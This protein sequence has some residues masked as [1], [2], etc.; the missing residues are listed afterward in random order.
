MCLEG[1]WRVIGRGCAL[2]AV[3]L[4]LLPLAA[5]AAAKT[6]AK[7]RVIERGPHHAEVQSI[8]TVVDAAGVERQVTRTYVTVGSGLHQFENGKW[9]PARALFEVRGREIVARKTAHKVSLASSPAAARPVVVDLPGGGGKQVSRVLGL[10]YYD[11]GSGRSVLLAEVRDVNQ[12]Q[13][14]ETEVIYPDAFDGGFRVDL[15]YRI[16]LAGL[17][18]DVIVRERPPAPEEYG[19]EAATTRLEVLT[20]FLSTPKPK[21]E[22]RRLRARGGDRRLADPEQTDDDVDFGAMVLGPG[23]AFA[24]AAERE[25]EVEGGG[26]A[27]TGVGIGVSKRWETIEGRQVLFEAVEWAEAAPLLEGL[28]AGAQARRE[29]VGGGERRVAQ[30]GRFELPGGTRAVPQQQEATPTAAAGAAAVVAG[31]GEAGLEPGAALLAVAPL[32][33]RESAGLVID[34]QTV[35]PATNFTFR[36]DTTYYV[37]NGLYLRGTTTIE[38]GTVVKYERFVAPNYVSLNLMGPVVCKTSAYRPGVFTAKDDDSVGERIQGSTGVVSGRYAWCSIYL[39]NNGSSSVL[40]HLQVRHTVRGLYAYYM[41]QVTTFRHV[42]V[43]NA[44]YGIMGYVANVKVGNALIVDVWYPFYQYSAPMAVEHATVQR[45][46]YLVYNQGNS[47]ISLVNSLLAQ[48]TNQTQYGSFA[49]SFTVTNASSAAFQNVG[50]GG[51]YLPAGSAHRDAGTSGIDAGLWSELQ[52]LT[53]EAPQVW[54]QAVTEDTTLGPRVS[55]DVGAPDLGYHYAPLDYCIGE[56]ALSN[57]TLRLVGGVALGFTGANGG[58]SLGQGAR[59]LSQGSPLQMNRWVRYLQVQEHAGGANDPWHGGNG[60]ATW[61]YLKLATSASSGWPEMRLRFTEVAHLAHAA[62]RRGLLESQGYPFGV[63]EVRDSRLMNVYQHVWRD[64]SGLGSGVNPVPVVG[65]TNNVIERGYVQWTQG[66]GNVPRALGVSLRNNLFWGGYVGFT[67]YT[68]QWPWAVH[69]NLFDGASL[70]EGGAGT[71]PMPVTHNAYTAGVTLLAGSKDHLKGMTSGY[72]SGPLGEYYYPESGAWPTLVNLRDKGSRAAGAAG[73]YYYTTRPGQS[74]ESSSVV[75]IGFH[76]LAVDASGRVLDS[77]GDGLEDYLEDDNGNGTIDAWESSPLA[78]DSD[79]DG[80]SDAQEARFGLNARLADSDGDGVSDGQ[81]DLD[82]DGMSVLEEL[83]LGTDPGNRDTDGDGVEDGD[84]DADGDLLTNRSELRKYG[85]NPALRRS[86]ASPHDDGVVKCLAFENDS[87]TELRLGIE[88]GTEEAVVTLTGTVA[89]R[90]YVLLSRTS[91]SGGSGS[92][93]IEQYVEGAAGGNVTQARVAYGGRE[94]LYVMA[95]LG[96]DS[97]GDGLVDAYEVYVLKTCP[98]A[99][100]SGGTATDDGYRDP[101][102]DQWTNMQ[103]MENRTDPLLFNSPPAPTGLQALISADNT[104][105]ELKWDPAPGPVVGYMVQSGFDDPVPV[106][107]SATSLSVD[108]PPNGFAYQLNHVHAL[109][110]RGP[111]LVTPGVVPQSEIGPPRVVNGANGRLFLVVPNRPRNAAFVRL[112]RL[113]EEPTTGLPIEHVYPQFDWNPLWLDGEY[114]T[115]G[116][117]HRPLTVNGSMDIPASSLVNGRFEIPL[118]FAPYFGRYCFQVQVVYEDGMLGPLQFCRGMVTT[119]VRRV[120]FIDGREMLE[121]NARFLLRAAT[122]SE[123][124]GYKIAIDGDD[125]DATYHAAAAHADYVVSDY[126][127]VDENYYPPKLW[128][129]FKPAQEN[130]FY[131]NWCYSADNVKEGWIATGVGYHIDGGQYYGR[132]FIFDPLHVFDE[133]GYVGLG[134]APPVAATLTAAAAKWIYHERLRSYPDTRVGLTENGTLGEGLKNIYGLPYVSLLRLAPEAENQTQAVAPGGRM[135]SPPGSTFQ[136]VKEPVLLTNGFYFTA[137]PRQIVGG[138]EWT[139]RTATPGFIGVVGQPMWIAGWERLSISNSPPGKAVFLGQ[140]FDKAYLADAEGEPTT[141]ETGILSEYGEFFPTEPGRVILVTKPGSSGARGECAIQVIGIALDAD[142]DG[143]M[144]LQYGGADQTSPERPLRFWV[145]DDYDAVDEGVDQDLE[146]KARSN[147]DAK[148]IAQIE[149]ERDLEDFAR[150]WLP[151]VE[152]VQVPGMRVLLSWNVRSGSPRINLFR[153]ENGGMGYLRSSDTARTIVAGSAASYIGELGAQLPMDLTEHMPTTGTPYFLFEGSS[154]GSGDLVLTLLSGWTFVGQ[155]RASLD[156]N[157]VRDLYEQVHLLGVPPT[158]SDRS[159]PAFAFDHVPRLQ[160]DERRELVVFVHGWRMTQWDFYSF[161]ESMFKRL[162]W[163]GFAGRV[164]SVRWPT[165][166]SDETWFDYRTFNASEYRAHH[167]GRALSDYLTHRKRKFPN[168]SIHV[169]AHSM[170]NTV[171][172]QALKRQHERGRN[173]VTTWVLMQA[174]VPAHCFDPGLSDYPKLASTQTTRPTP[175][176]YR[177]VLNGISTRARLVSFV[178]EEDYALATGTLEP[179]PNVELPIANWESHQLR[180]KPDTSHYYRSHGE[181]GYKFYF[182]PPPSG[183]LPQPPPE[184]IKY[185]VSDPMEM[186]AFVARPR[187]KAVGAVLGVGG[188]LDQTGETD[189]GGTAYG[190]GRSDRDHS[191]QFNWSIQRLDAFY[192]QLVDVME[193]GAGR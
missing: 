43:V 143:A 8:E 106:P 86:A 104:K 146:T 173:D 87:G 44:H 54:T 7:T 133:P 14:V 119:H 35:V 123:P 132:K 61:S 85:T 28:P 164:A 9:E 130:R 81:E 82:Y 64:A 112:V 155:A 145:N 189:L 124:F 63:Y 117:A 166:S 36:S 160:T 153:V 10:G 34:Y 182:Q 171:M 41:P 111:S 100:D 52:Q 184:I 125:P 73:L 96:E 95:G 152:G 163:Q 187:S 30:A 141:Q 98:D 167:S 79:A 77:D 88:R 103:E 188:F 26:G 51:Q 169:C 32:D 183:P 157:P 148:H 149:S 84:E 57:A 186:M 24:L 135:L 13:A 168:W 192:R 93:V 45:G 110:A 83:A 105:I 74:P 170:G 116:K 177:S 50:A 46:A 142:H 72:A 48:V 71:I 140:Y 136:E 128:N 67:Y 58:L 20:E 151:G 165:H 39:Y 181:D 12:P 178:N 29:G 31:R 70:A 162:Y 154:A 53:T 102:E 138:P 49:R 113:V 108:A 185:Y 65:W 59:L 99:G 179:L 16:S 174:A 2:I 94:A 172:M 134:N 75:D 193:V 147:I 139:P 115:R 150:L 25:A 126:V 101:D 19:L 40:K 161:S 120:P 131:H 33:A 22:R 60:G 68:A 92:W 107:A 89:E 80:L 66:Y 56:V 11:A 175:D 144:D 69:E 38:G 6:S 97:D 5:G 78:G 62:L 159:Q 90:M 15:R 18:Q 109:Y 118:E 91:V 1:P 27:G 23:R 37:T 191:G 55:R 158:P 114:Q 42:Q 3:A 180:S 176:T 156:L 122:M 21:V 4:F 76:Y 121:Q 17:E 137:N 190:F 127:Q 129:E 47:T